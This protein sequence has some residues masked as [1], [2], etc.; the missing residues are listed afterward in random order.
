MVHLA[1][2]QRNLPTTIVFA[3]LPAT[4]RYEDRVKMLLELSSCVDHLYLITKEC[5]KT[6]L[7]NSGKLTILHTLGN[8]E[9]FSFLRSATSEVLK[10]IQ[11]LPRKTP[12]I[13]HDFFFARVGP[14]AKLRFPMRSIRTVVS[15]YGANIEMLRSRVWRQE[16]DSGFSRLDLCYYSLLIPRLLSEVYSGLTSDILIGNSDQIT[17]DWNMYFRIPKSKLAVVHSS[18]DTTFFVPRVKTNN[19]SGYRI[20]Y[21]GRIL[22]YRKGIDTLLDSFKQVAQYSHDVTLTLLGKTDPENAAVLD[23]IIHRHPFADRIEVGM[24]KTREELISYYQQSDVYVSAS[25][26]EGSPRALKEALSCG[27]PA[28]V[29]DIRG[30]RILDMSESRLHFFEPRNCNQLSSKLIDLLN[31][32]ESHDRIDMHDWVNRKFSCQ[33]VASTILGVYRQLLSH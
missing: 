11:R 13:I 27:L 21:V 12:I 30:H 25:V 2:L 33:I 20:I 32:L 4:E 31:S 26:N 22:V 15:I 28:L 14:M 6:T 23:E 18:V 16:G 17:R 8:R 1:S 3:I 19:G 24:A 7:R 9:G 29:S 10:R 5:P